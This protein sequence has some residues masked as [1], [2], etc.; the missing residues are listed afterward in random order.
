[1][2]ELL[3]I[4]LTQ[5]I[6]LV[7][8]IDYEGSDYLF[9]QRAGALA[10]NDLVEAFARDGICKDKS[11]IALVLVRLRDLQVRDYAMGITS[12][13]NIETLWEMWR[14]LL[15]ITPAGYVAPAAS[16]FSAVSYEKGE[17]ALASKSLDKSLTDDPRYPLA[18]LLRRVYAAG[19]PPES[20]M[21]MRK[22]LHPKVCAALF[23]E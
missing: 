21:A 11:L 8:E 14:W 16:L 17:L 20:F 13:E 7:E 23:N 3:D 19:W 9:K 22:D 1:M 5:L 12:N 2:T 6:E 15:Q 4:E 18:L 10:F